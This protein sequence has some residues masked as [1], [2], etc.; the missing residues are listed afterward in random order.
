MP[1]GRGFFT[2]DRY[3][4]PL[5]SAEVADIDLD[6][7]KLAHLSISRKG[8]VPG[9]LICY[10][11]RVI[12]QGYK[13][14]DVFYQL[15]S[16]KVE[17]ERRLE[18]NSSRSRRFMFAGRDSC[19]M[20]A[21]G[22][23]PSIVSAARMPSM[24]I[25]TAGSYYARR[26]SKACK[27]SL[28]NIASKP[29]KSK[30]CWTIPHRKAIYL[31]L[32]AIGLQ[33]SGDLSAAF[34]HCEKLIDLEPDQMPLDTISKLLAVR[35]DRWIQAQLASLC[36]E[37]KGETAA[38]INDAIRARFQAAA[39]SGSIESLQ[40]FM[41]YFGNQPVAAEARSESVRKLIEA[42]RYLEAEMT[43]WAKSPS[44]EPAANAPALAEVADMLR[45]AGNKDSAVLTYSWLC[46][47]L[48]KEVCRDGK[49]AEQLVKELPADD[50]IRGTLD[51]K[52]SWPIGNVESTE[53]D[54]KN[55]LNINYGRI[56]LGIKGKSRSVFC[57]CESVLRPK[58]AHAFVHRFVGQQFV[59]NCVDRRSF[60]KNAVYS[61]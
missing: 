38:K 59:A 3:F 20:P 48:G 7:G 22:R 8:I 45:Q 13:G 57:K 2:G 42:H 12:S 34:E 9:N 25:P 10:K 30:N 19:W 43:V 15:D 16:A 29:P 27:M 53:N 35:R 49:T 33:K 11:G 28:P 37:A 40:R 52:D 56:P 31:R 54:K 50:A 41:D 26:C 23:K 14:V 39:A 58:P 51:R 21:N 17:I 44:L 55:N 24:P 46:R 4:V 60:A 1:S 18:T 47:R 36:M 32:M 6:K 61:V 5:D